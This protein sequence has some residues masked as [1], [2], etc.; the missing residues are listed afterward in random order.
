[1]AAV[2]SRF[3]SGFGSTICTVKLRERP[4]V[5][6]AAPFESAMPPA[7][8]SVAR[9]VIMPMIHGKAPPAQRPSGRK[10]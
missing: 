2:C 4:P 9:K 6:A 10:R 1:M 5:S 8:A 7:S 3:T